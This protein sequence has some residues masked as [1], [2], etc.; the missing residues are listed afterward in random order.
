MSIAVPAT[1]YEVEWDYDPTEARSVRVYVG[2]FYCAAK[3]ELVRE[4]GLFNAIL[5]LAAAVI[6]RLEWWRTNTLKIDLKKGDE[7]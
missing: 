4:V 6:S 3:D 1:E 7:R 5:L 2:A